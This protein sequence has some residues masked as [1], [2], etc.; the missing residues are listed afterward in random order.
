[1]LCGG[2]VWYREN[3]PSESGGGGYRRYIGVFLDVWR[4]NVFMKKK[5]FFIICAVRIL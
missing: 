2:V 1:M 3:T 4:I 5:V